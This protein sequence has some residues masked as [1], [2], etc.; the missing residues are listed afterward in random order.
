[1]D[2]KDIFKAPFSTDDYGIYMFDADNNI[3]LE[4]NSNSYCHDD[5]VLKQLCA[6]P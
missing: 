5:Y 4:Y 1:M 6:I 2:F 3:C